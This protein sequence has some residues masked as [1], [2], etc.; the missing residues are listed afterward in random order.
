MKKN[1]LFII[2]VICYGIYLS[3][4]A[5]INHKNHKQAA[6]DNTLSPSEKTKGYMLLFNG[7]S[8]TGWRTYQNKHGSWSVEDNTLYCHK[9][10]D[11]H[12]ADL[13]TNDQ[14]ENFELQVDWKIEPN[15]NSGIMYMVTEQY[16]QSYLSGPEYQLLD[17]KGY[18]GKVEDYQKT[19]A[20]YAI[21]AP[22]VDATKPV[23]EWNHT[24][25]SV[26]KGHVEHWLN[27]KKVVE[28][29][30]WSAEWKAA[31]EHGKWKDAAGYG[32]SKMG[33]IALQDFHG[34]G[35]VWFKNIKL[36]KL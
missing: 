6:M 16:E 5:H 3:A 7:T 22:G 24:V 18:E 20:A 30:L 31:K 12:Y 29:E 8:T 14:Y 33:H 13:I 19:A 11:G 10:P 36:R 27:G 2:T 15:A 25:I 17:N 1:L 23:G 21:K 28:Y 34:D 35:K 26:N 32:M 9:M 4:S